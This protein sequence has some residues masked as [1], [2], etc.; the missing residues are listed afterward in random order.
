[1]LCLLSA[2]KD[3]GHVS[4]VCVECDSVIIMRFWV[5][6]STIKNIWYAR[7]ADFRCRLPTAACRRLW[8]SP[9]E[10]LQPRLGS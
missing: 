10:Q 3:A 9:G 6:S 4:H 2:R 1:M 7:K 5:R 8:T